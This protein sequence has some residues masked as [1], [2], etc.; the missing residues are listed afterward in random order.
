MREHKLR[1]GVIGVGFYAAGSLIPSLWATG[2]AEIV[3]IARR[4]PD[5]L[6]LAQRELNVS[7]AYTDWRE[8]LEKSSLDAVVISTPPNTHAEPTVAALD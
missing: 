8:M 3:A 7:E 4:S 6:R 2:R 5:R 1:I